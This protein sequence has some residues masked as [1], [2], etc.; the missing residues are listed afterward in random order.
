[1][2]E[3]SIFVLFKI[4]YKRLWA[5]ALAF[6]LAATVAFSY[7]RIIVSPV[8]GASA[9]IIVTNGAIIA[10]DE[11]STTQKLLGSDIQASL[12]L[13]DSVVD[14]LKTP[15][16]YKYLAQKLGSDV[17]YKMLKASTSVVRR[18]EDT[19]FIDISFSDSDPQRAIKTVNM[20]A[21]ASC[22]YVAGFI[23]KSDPQ[24]VS[25]ADRA[26]LV[27]PRTYRSTVLA[28]LAAAFITYLVFVLVELFNNTV[29]GE[30]DFVARHDI[31]VLGTVP[32]FDEARKKKSYRKG[33]Y[34]L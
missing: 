30:E 16:I 14:I 3:V 34:T 23:S 8:Y 31:P 12:L 33:G 10:T 22:D 13:V 5:L 21:A 32:D 25:S 24:I 17:D 26:T 2:Q 29:R 15:D 18:G 4:A 11:S 28:G 27:S 20:F 1:M 9:S 19:L 6:V 7:C